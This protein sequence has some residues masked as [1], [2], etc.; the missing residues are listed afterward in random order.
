MNAGILMIDDI[1]ILPLSALQDI[2]GPHCNPFLTIAIAGRPDTGRPQFMMTAISNG[3]PHE[4]VISTVGYLR[5]LYD[6]SP[7]DSV[8]LSNDARIIFQAEDVPVNIPSASWETMNAWNE[9]ALVPDIYYFQAMGYED[10]IPESIGWNDRVSKIFW[11]GSST[12]L[13]QQRL[14][15]LDS[16]PRYRLCQ[17]VSRLGA[18][19]DVGLNAVV[20]AGDPHQERLIKE[21]LLQEGL[22]K[23]FIPMTEMTRYRYILDIDGNSNSWNF[24]MKLRLGSCVLRVDSDWHQWFASRL[25]PW[26][27]YVPIA[28]DLSDAAEKIAWCLDNESECA[29]I[30]EHGLAFARSMRFK[31][32]MTA[33]ATNVYS[34]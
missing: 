19:A 8:N 26:V 34:M 31:D 6:A 18:I 24:M 27:H 29:A 12:G 4:R 20:Q 13:F 32:E 15:D 23:S 21:R 28:K 10:W 22:L 9:V 30:A 5:H 3:A 14:E 7:K 1:S 25:A 11:R 16:L 17:I 33:A 2:I